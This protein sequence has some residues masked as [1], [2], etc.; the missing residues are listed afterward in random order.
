MS[1][2]IAFYSFTCTLKP[3]DL[4]TIAKACSEAVATK[5]VT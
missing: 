5:I 2:D 3:P 4:K 1:I